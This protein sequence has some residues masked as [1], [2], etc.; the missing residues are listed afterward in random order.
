MPGLLNVLLAFPFP[1]VCVAL[2]PLVLLSPQAAGQSHGS[3]AERDARV[4]AFL[5]RSARFLALP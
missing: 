2:A 4:R 1:F 3:N 5:K